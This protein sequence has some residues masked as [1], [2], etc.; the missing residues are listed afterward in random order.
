MYSMLS[1]FFWP[2]LQSELSSKGSLVDAND[3]IAIVV[4][5]QEE[6][7]L[8]RSCTY[9]HSTLLFHNEV[10][11]EYDLIVE[12]EKVCILHLWHQKGSQCTLELREDIR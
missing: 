12:R 11:P 3:F 9:T 6:F 2:F 4:K 7:P 5:E 8:Q 10:F 1:T